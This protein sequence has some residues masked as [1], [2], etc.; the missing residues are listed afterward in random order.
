MLSS[1]SFLLSY[2]G[3]TARP[4]II[5]WARGKSG[6][7]STKKKERRGGKKRLKKRD[8]KRRKKKE[9]LFSQKIGQGRRALL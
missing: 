5:F 6:W 9:V 7:N 4:C 3:K 8:K 2:R 1:V